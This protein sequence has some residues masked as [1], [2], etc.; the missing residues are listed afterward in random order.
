MCGVFRFTRTMVKLVLF[1]IDGTLIRTGGAGVRAFERTFAEQFGLIEATKTLKFSG[2]TDVSLVRE[3]FGQHG[4]ET[5]EGNFRHFFDN[6]PRHLE[7]L[8][9]TLP[10]GI[11]EGIEG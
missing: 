3:C 11:C 6:Y 9:G 5:S 2:R 10:E 1:D 7:S 4:I 8:L